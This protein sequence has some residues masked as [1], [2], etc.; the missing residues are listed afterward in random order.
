MY[1]AFKQLGTAEQGKIVQESVFFGECDIVGQTWAGWIDR[2]AVLRNVIR[3]DCAIVRLRLLFGVIERQM[4]AA[5]L[6][7]HRLCRYSLQRNP[8]LY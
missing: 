8:G 3:S 7:Q 5:A 4:V 2:N 1:I 6:V